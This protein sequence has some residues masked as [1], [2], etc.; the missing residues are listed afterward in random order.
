MPSV[1]LPQGTIHFRE[2]GDGPPVVLLHGLLLDGRLFDEV[3]PLLRDRFRVLV[4][5]LPL[6]CHRTALR[7]EADLSPWGVARLIADFAEALDLRDTT[8]V[9]NDSGGAYGH[10]SATQ[11]PARVGRLVLS[12]CDL[13]DNFVP[14]MFQPLRALA[15]V[16]GSSR[17]LG[18]TLRFRAVQRLPNAYGWLSHKPLDPAL[19]ASMTEPLR[20]D[21]GVRRDLAKVLR[22][23]DAAA[24]VQAAEDLAAFD[25]PTLWAWGGDDRFFPVEQARRLARTMPD[26]RFEVIP[27]SRTYTPIDQPERLAALI[28]EFAG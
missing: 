25:R 21:A 4:P 14:P 20:R 7:P 23:I 13:E 8:L 6:G 1:D 27:N 26:A 10:V 5:D 19:V 2:G 28:A 12:S 3:V 9:G 17:L 16:P 11:H 18:A 22:G 15:R 24:T